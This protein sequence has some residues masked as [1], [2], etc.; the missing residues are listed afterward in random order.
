MVNMKL[1][2]GVLS[3][4]YDEQLKHLIGFGSRINPKRG[5][6]FVSKVLGK[7][8]PTKPSQM[9][10]IYNMLAQKT[11]HKLI[12]DKP[13]LVIGFAE[14]AT[15][16]GHGVFE[17][18]RD[19][20]GVKDIF[21]IHSTRFMTSEDTLLEFY[22]EH[23]HAPSHII[24]K[25]RDEELRDLLYDVGN[26]VLVDDEVSTGRTVSNLIE[27]LKH[28][29]PGVHNYILVTIL[30]WIEGKHDAFESVALHN[31]SFEFNWHYESEGFDDSCIVSEPEEKV[32]LDEII[33]YNFGRHGIDKLH[34]II[35][36]NVDADD[37]RDKRVLVLGTAEFMYPPY[38]F[39]LSLEQSGIDVYFQATTRSPVN[40]DGD[41]ES[42]IEFKD[43][44]FE[45]IDNF[46]YNVVDKEYDKIFI[47]YETTQQPKNFRLKQILNKHGFLDVEELNF[48]DN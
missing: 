40:V 4:S 48:R 6:L 44:Y 18:L 46:L 24:Y 41:I 10:K 23:C 32:F 12:E 25:P 17:S 21:Y 30:N 36:S 28:R 14:T 42:K 16:L 37:L 39:A 5:Y 38:L 11:K 45:N 3:V 27:Q 8:I 29:L 22:E 33:P 34:C 43:N 31:G 1:K 15:A 20:C 35:E 9:K 19:D 26:V 7:H 2:T 47:C 13:T